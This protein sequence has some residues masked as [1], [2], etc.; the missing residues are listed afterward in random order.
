MEWKYVAATGNEAI[1]IPFQMWDGSL[2]RGRNVF[3]AGRL[4]GSFFTGSA[5]ALHPPAAITETGLLPVAG[6]TCLG[7]AFF[8]VQS[9][10]VPLLSM[11]LYE[12]LLLAD[13]HKALA[14]STAEAASKVC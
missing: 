2:S 7:T 5:T 1:H 6:A 3:D 14:C 11:W 12:R 10:P 13:R 8:Q 4:D 9:L